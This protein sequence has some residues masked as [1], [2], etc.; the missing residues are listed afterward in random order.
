MKVEYLFEP[1]PPKV[2]AQKGKKKV[3]Y[4]TSGKKNQITVI[5]CGSATGQALPPFVIF[6]AKQLNP[7]GKF[8]VPDMD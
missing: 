4:R 8:L 5:G 1:R 3:R 2:V 7:L 6:D